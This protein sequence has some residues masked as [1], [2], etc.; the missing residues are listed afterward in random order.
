M[1]NARPKNGRRGSARR[2]MTGRNQ[3]LGNTQ[4]AA[5]PATR[6]RIAN[7]TNNAPPTGPAA[8]TPNAEKIMVSNLPQ[9][10]SE[11]QIKVSFPLS[12]GVED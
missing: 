12:L 6:A 1:Q 5:A 10:V 7:T 8:K 11:A 2:A 3:I 4:P 9:D